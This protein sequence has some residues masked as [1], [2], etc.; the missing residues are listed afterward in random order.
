MTEIIKEEG[1]T[2]VKTGARI[3]TLNAAQFEQEIQP[4]LEQG[5]NL[6]IDCTE[7][8]YMASS[9]LRIL[10]ATMRTVVRSLGGQMK[11]THVNDDIFDILKMTGFTRHITVERV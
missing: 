7:L 11:L 5:V 2:I 9:G 3:D 6:E 8:G 4:A 10:Q 1:K